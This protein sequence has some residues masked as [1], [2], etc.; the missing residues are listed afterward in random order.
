LAQVFNSV[1][2]YGV[3][4]PMALLK[5]KTQVWQEG[6]CLSNG[7]AHRRLSFEDERHFEREWQARGL[8]RRCANGLVAWGI[9]TLDDVRAAT[10]RELLSIPQI[11]TQ[12]LL[13][14]CE[15]VG[16]DIPSGEG[17]R[18]EIQAEYERVW[19][20]K[21]GDKRFERILDLIINMAGEVLDSPTVNG[22]QALWSAARRRR[23]RL[24]RKPAIRNREG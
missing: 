12:G 1:T 15:L 9:L 11:G 10:D 19:R 3:T 4:A 5:L 17:T 6:I 18:K 22:G 8:T 13:A 23:A 14:V 16:R 7:S 24:G 21:V 2:A 20:A